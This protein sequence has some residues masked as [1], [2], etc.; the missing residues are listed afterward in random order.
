MKENK[1]KGNKNKCRKNLTSFS[2]RVTQKNK[3][4]SGWTHGN[5][6]KQRHVRKK[7][8]PYSNEHKHEKHHSFVQIKRN[9]TKMRTYNG[10]FKDYAF[11]S[12]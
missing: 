4:I 12:R 2:G 5:L 8:A 6:E 1:V 3:K 7:T 10:C 11:F 9:S